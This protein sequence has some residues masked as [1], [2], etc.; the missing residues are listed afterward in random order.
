MSTPALNP[1][2]YANSTVADMTGFKNMDFL[3]AHGSGDDNVSPPSPTPARPTLIYPRAPAQ[4]HFLNTAVLLDR[5]TSAHVR[6]FRFRMF[7][8]SDHSMSMRGAC[9]LLFRDR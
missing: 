4:V 9:E 3:L 8:D 1:Q 6:R 2:G 5:L 7:T